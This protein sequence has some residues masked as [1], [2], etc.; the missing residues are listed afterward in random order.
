MSCPLIV[1]KIKLKYSFWGRNSRFYF[2]FPKISENFEN[3]YLGNERGYKFLKQT[4]KGVF[5]H[6]GLE[7][8][9]Q[10]N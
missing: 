9:Y 6:V 5:L 1:K 2:E 7:S 10:K 4:S 8:Q 3:E